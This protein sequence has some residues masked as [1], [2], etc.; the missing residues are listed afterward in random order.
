M[1]PISRP[2]VS[3]VIPTYNMEQHI[4]ETLISVQSQTLES[5]EAIVVDDC[6]TDSTPRIVN[7][8]V[9]Q[10]PRI[11]YFRLSKNSNLPA[12]PRNYGIRQSQGKYVALLDH[13]DLW[14]PQKLQRQVQVLDADET[15]AMIHSHLWVVRNGRRLWG[16]LYL[17]SPRKS[18]A[19][20]SKLKKS[21]VIQCSSVAIRKDVINGLGGFDESLELRAVEDYHLWFRVS[22]HHRIAF[23]SEIHGACRHDST[24]TSARENMQVRLQGIDR[25]VGT[26]SFASQQSLL[27]K[28]GEKALRFP[29]ALFYLAIE[30]RYRQWFG[31]PPRSW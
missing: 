19:T 18:I 8:F 2:L 12:V 6:S 25:A 31:A 23:I 15:I 4:S 5:W 29:S 21:N 7:E 27:R 9:E 11:R 10:D 16:L 14:S 17:P 22:Q 28:A 20:E 1:K 24:G 13:D 3:V 30:G 26:V